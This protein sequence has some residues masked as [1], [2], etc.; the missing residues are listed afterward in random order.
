M[1][2]ATRRA[3]AAS[4]LAAVFI[5]ILVP[6]GV[7]PRTT[8]AARSAPTPAGP[9]AIT[10]H[11][12]QPLG[13]INRGLGG[14]DWHADGARLDTVAP[15]HP[16]FVRIDA[17]L[18]RVSPEPGVL[19]LGD[20]LQRVAAVRAV[21]GEPLVILSY[22]PAWLGQPHALGDRTKT[23]PTNLATW[24]QLVHDV[25]RAL[26]TAPAPAYWFEAWNEP[27]V[28][29][30][31]AG[32]PTDW[33]AMAA[34]SGHAVRQVQTETGRRLYFGG[35]ATAIPDPAYLLTFLARFRDGSLPLDFISWHYY[36]NYPCFGPDGPEP[37]P[38]S[39]LT[40][41][42]GC[43]NPFA[44]P[45]AFGPQ[46]ALMRTLTAAGLAGSGRT[47][48]R[49]ILDEWNLSAGGYDVRH[50]TAF[51]ASFDAATLIE[52]QEAG[53]DDAAFF[54]A[55]D[56]T[57]HPG[58]WGLVRLD[59]TRKP[60]WWTFALWHQLPP[61]RVTV[62]GANPLGGLWA[63]ASR[64]PS[65]GRTGIEIV[66]FAATGGTP[67][68]ASVLLD[69]GPSTSTQAATVQRIDADHPTAAT[70]TPLALDHGRIVVDIPPQS[71][72][73]LEVTPAPSTGA[74]PAQAGTK[75]AATGR[76][77]LAY[78]GAD[79]KVTLLAA[80]VAMLAAVGLGLRRRVR[81]TLRRGQE[82]P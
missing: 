6:A 42:F 67:R 17:S 50:D 45:L 43:R 8:A 13:S 2:V 51:G 4:A 38:V 65:T 82:T 28:P 16:A 22:T 18:E 46:V 58:G 56:T 1:P 64:D 52:L 34:A 31:W 14:L 20:L 26:A 23:P 21:G 35:P 12:D 68:R 57:D 15:L 75:D 55:T 33:V 66:S 60:A 72:T 27:D 80:L 49:L 7:S 11:L 40:N 53:L 54:M 25:V 44:S 48:P 39:G 19:N 3:G 29:T 9:T 79:N 59:G 63:I 70:K 47:A 74:P 36:G 10:V 62:D 61:N 30:F 37:S 78:T 73:Y 71:V 32:T 69:G 41:L 76:P 77:A 24:Q 5:A 81:S